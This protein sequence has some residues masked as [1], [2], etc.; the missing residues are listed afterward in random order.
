MQ[1]E[2][3]RGRIFLTR[4]SLLL[5]VVVAVLGGPLGGLLSG[6]PRGLLGGGR[7]CSGREGVGRLAGL[8]LGLWWHRDLGRCIQWI[9]N[10]AL[11]M[12]QK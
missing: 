6:P 7:C 3:K 1:S 11:Q 8:R 2:D 10:L 9:P 12:I 5:V 4:Q